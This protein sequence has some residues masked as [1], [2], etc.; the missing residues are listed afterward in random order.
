MMEGT[1]PAQAGE[2]DTFPHH[3]FTTEEGEKSQRCFLLQV[4][5]PKVFSALVLNSTQTII[6][7][8]R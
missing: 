8:D 4:L 1:S 7:G 3:Y 2:T 6:S 5:T